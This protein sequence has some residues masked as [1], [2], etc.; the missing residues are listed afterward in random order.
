MLA[1]MTLNKATID[2]HVVPGIAMPLLKMAAMT[3]GVFSVEIPDG[4][5]VVKSGNAKEGDLALDL[6]SFLASPD[7]RP[8]YATVKW[9][10][11][12]DRFDHS[13]YGLL[14]R[15]VAG[16]QEVTLEQRKQD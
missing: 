9:D 8:G 15:K 16:T 13:C 5:S 1:E 10:Y 6:E 14:I 2:T 11:V 4:W 7:L 12:G 3:N